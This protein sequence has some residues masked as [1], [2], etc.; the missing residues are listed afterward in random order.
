VLSCLWAQ[1]YGL[2]TDGSADFLDSDDDGMNDWQEFVAGTNPTNA[3]SVLKLNPLPVSGHNVNWRSVAGIT[4]YLQRSTH[5]TRQPFTTIDSNIVGNAG[6]T[7][8]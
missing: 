7:Y 1:Q 3:A 2:P 4:C 8:Q 5:L 6:I